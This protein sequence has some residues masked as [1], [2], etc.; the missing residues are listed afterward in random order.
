M[1]R[2][3]RRLT[4][5]VF[6][7]ATFV[8][9]AMSVLFVV[10]RF[11]VFFLTHT[12]TTELRNLTVSNG[13]LWYGWAQFPSSPQSA[14]WVFTAF[15]RMRPEDPNFDP[16]AW[17]PVMRSKPRNSVIVVPLWTIGVPAAIAAAWAG[18]SLRRRR[19]HCRCGYSLAGL[20]DT[21]PCP[22]CGS[23][24]DEAS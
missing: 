21:T 4:I 24:R 2:G 14:G 12:T 16:L 5:A 6:V 9:V 3:R 17:W 10:N 11:R 23:A 20:A 7:A 15:G 8:L 13:A 19:G 22:E 18:R 1:E